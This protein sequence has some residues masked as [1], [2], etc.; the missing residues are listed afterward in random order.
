MLLGNGVAHFYEDE[1]QKLVV[2]YDKSINHI[3]K[4]CRLVDYGSIQMLGPTYLKKHN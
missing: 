2:Q 3:R 4:L 1:I